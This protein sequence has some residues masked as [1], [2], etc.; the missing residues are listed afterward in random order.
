MGNYRLGFGKLRDYPARDTG[1]KE[2]AYREELR[3]TSIANL[4]AWELPNLNPNNNNTFHDPPVAWRSTLGRTATTSRR[5]SRRPHPSHTAPPLEVYRSGDEGFGS[6]SGQDYSNPAAF[7]AD[8]NARRVQAATNSVFRGAFYT[9]MPQH[10]EQLEGLG[11]REPLTFEPSHGV[12]VQEVEDSGIE[13]DEEEDEDMPDLV[14]A[15]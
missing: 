10:I 2:R 5:I 14:V 8:E 1:L 15:D 6:L 11:G 12:E 4:P 7:E 3:S 13:G 9:S